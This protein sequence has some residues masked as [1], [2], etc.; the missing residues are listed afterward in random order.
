MIVPPVDNS[1]EIKKAVDRFVTVAYTSPKLMQ[2]I[3]IAVQAFDSASTAQL[4]L[5]VKQGVA[6]GGDIHTSF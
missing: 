1:A 4:I 5:H 3:K 2:F 6:K